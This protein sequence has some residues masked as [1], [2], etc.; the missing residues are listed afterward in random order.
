MIQ[1]GKF[2]WRESEET[3]KYKERGKTIWYYHNNLVTQR[4]IPCF[5]K[6]YFCQNYAGILTS[7]ALEIG[8]EQWSDKN[9]A[10]YK[11]NHKV[12]KKF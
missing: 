3:E 6:G 10:R 4:S 5:L 9:E 12:N 2:R 8:V 7:G 1:N 11:K